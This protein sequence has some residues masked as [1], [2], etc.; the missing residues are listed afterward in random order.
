M[1]FKSKNGKEACLTYHNYCNPIVKISSHRNLYEKITQLFLFFQ[2]FLN[3]AVFKV[4][5]CFEKHKWLPFEFV[6]RRNLVLYTKLCPFSH[7]TCT[8]FEV[9]A[10]SGWKVILFSV[11]N[12]YR[13]TEETNK[14]VLGHKFTET[15]L[16]TCMWKYILY[17]WNIFSEHPVY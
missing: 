11:K 1:M 16:F 12:A 5:F 7:H 17:Y 4:W 9:D 8:Q 6:Q 3:T 15:V 14:T 13:K 2:F 10:W